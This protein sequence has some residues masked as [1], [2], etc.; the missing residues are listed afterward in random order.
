MYRPNKNLDFFTVMPLSVE[1]D[2]SFSLA[3]KLPFLPQYNTNGDLPADETTTATIEFNGDTFI[4]VIETSDDIDWIEITGVSGGE[5]LNITFE[6]PAGQDPA[7]YIPPIISLIAIDSAGVQHDLGTPVNFSSFYIE[8]FG[9]GTS[10]Y[11]QVGDGDTIDN[12]EYAISLSTSSD[13]YLNNINTTGEI[14]VDG[15][16]SGVHE[17]ELDQ[18]WFRLDVEA[19]TVYEI[20]VEGT[21]RLSFRDA[22][23]NSFDNFSSIYDPSTGGRTYVISQAVGETI[24]IQS[25]FQS[26]FGYPLPSTYNISVNATEVG[27]DDHS[28]NFTPDEATALTVGDPLTGVISS[29]GDDDVFYTEFENGVEYSFEV[30]SGVTL[31]I[32]DSSAST[33]D[34]AGILSYDTDAVTGNTI[35]SFTPFDPGNFYIRIQNTNSSGAFPIDYT[36]A[37]S[38]ENLPFVDL[39]DSTSTRAEPDSYTVGT[40]LSGQGN[41]G[42]LPDFDYYDFTV[43][44][45]QVIFFDTVHV[46]D[47]G[48]LSFSILDSEGNVLNPNFD[49]FI[50]DPFNDLEFSASIY[51]FTE[52]GTYTLATRAGSYL[53][54]DEIVPFDFAVLGT[55]IPD[56]T[57]P[58]AF[59]ELYGPDM[60]LWFPTL[61]IGALPTVTPI[62]TSVSLDRLTNPDGSFEE[63]LSHTVNAGE[64]MYSRDGALITS[65][66]EEGTIVNNGTMWS[67]S[68]TTAIGG[69][70][71]AVFENNGLF[72]SL[73]T[74][75]ATGLSFNQGMNF[76]NNGDFFV[77]A[78]DGYAQ[79]ISA[80]S[81]NTLF[82][83]GLNYN[84]GSMI[85]QSLTSQARAVFF[86]NEV[87]FVNS[88]TIIVDGFT[89][90]LAIVMGGDVTNSGDIT[91][92]VGLLGRE[93][94]GIA[95]S[96]SGYLGAVTNT[97]TITADIAL[98]MDQFSNVDNSGTLNGDV[99]F[100]S[101]GLSANDSG[102]TSDLVNSGIINGDVFFDDDVSVYNGIGGFVSGIISLGGG[103]DIATGGDFTDFIEGGLGNDI[104]DGGAGVDIAFYEAGLISD[105]TITYNDDGSST[106][107]H[108]IY[109][110]DEL[111]NF[112]FI[113]IAD[114][115]YSL[116]PIVTTLTDRSDIYT[117]V[118]QGETI[119]GLRG[120]DT[121]YGM[122]GNDIIEGGGGR[123]IIDGGDGIDTA[124]YETS[125]NRV[126]IN[127]ATNS[128]NS[129]HATGDVLISIENITGTRF[130]DT[131][132]GNRRD[133]VIIGE[134]GFDV[135]SGFHGDDV[136]D[137]G[138][139]R[140]FLT[141]GLGADVIDGGADIDMARY[142]GSNAG[143]DI[144]LGAGTASGGHAEG[145]V[146]IDIEQ[147]FGSNHADILIGNEQN[148]FIFGS[149]GDDILD[150]AGGID[151]LFGGAGADTFVFGAGDG[152]TFVTDWQDDIDSLDLSQ[153]NFD[154]VAD[155]V[156]NMNQFGAHV[157]FFVDGET[158]L[159][160]NANLDDI[161][162]DIIISN[163]ATV[164]KPS[165]IDAFFA[166]PATPALVA[167]WADDIEN[168]NLTQSNLS[169]IEAVIANNVWP[170]DSGGAFADGDMSSMQQM[171]FDTFIDDVLI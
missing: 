17:A 24:F 79:G 88:G 42:D 37:S 9:P 170:V 149:G 103:D 59:Q 146:L 22:D 131:I 159:I 48:Y 31:T 111:T 166:S 168:V 162:D 96:S 155:A 104:L 44:D 72:V 10:Y 47:E 5:S 157:R 2:L 112:E 57:I 171:Y 160:L 12:G 120:N 126:V 161:I 32:F 77:F 52:G 134:G 4:G 34:N 144:N 125:T 6:V 70:N 28:D 73:G 87:S 123:D 65:G 127:M 25:Q 53:S 45:G 109:G 148:N 83:D 62:G 90:A 43:T 68:A 49:P 142:V 154:S 78:T 97:G 85:V 84:A 137:G 93:S 40:V 101:E 115:L 14:V 58:D 1:S 80:A 152:Y 116:E 56:Y 107:S 86:I 63:N 139:G 75:S 138:A 41:F 95:P 27:P 76:H 13:D 141:G 19:D 133:N 50:V 36:L 46:R 147:V 55:F 132:T 64:T 106:V 124:S 61:D 89:S 105:F 54:D 130:A 164:A 38:S 163:E 26:G 29:I 102:L 11:L 35:V 71:L 150:G 66:V 91:A 129:G 100:F 39:D 15:I 8:D 60:A 143:V 158:L 165:D 99:V 16:T 94:V 153:Y 121:L 3:P 18:D 122:G 74:F 21:A 113:Q 67:N 20:T 108:V 136:L 110:T 81:E 128:L 151:K 92:T 119:Y 145:D 7:F 135:L 118:D 117:G 51:R 69:T 98:L 169:R 82:G 30:E 167:D 140:D 23:G 33:V 156:A 114:E